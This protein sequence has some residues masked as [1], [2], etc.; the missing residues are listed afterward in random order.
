MSDHRPKTDDERPDP[1]DEP[2][3]LYSAHDAVLRR[4]DGSEIDLNALVDPFTGHQPA[5]AGPLR[6]RTHDDDDAE[7]AA[8]EQIGRRLRVM[9]Q[10]AGLSQKEVAERLAVPASKISDVENGGIVAGL[11]LVS[12]MVVAVGARLSDLVSPGGPDR[13]NPELTKLAVAA[14]VPPDLLKRID[15]EVEPDEYPDALARGFAWDRDELMTGEPHTPMLAFDPVYKTVGEPPAP[16]SPILALAWTLSSVA[17]SSY[18]MTFSG[19]PADPRELRREILAKHRSVALESVLTWSWD[20]GVV[21]LPL[22]AKGDFVAAVWMVEQ[23]PTIVL[24]E[25]RSIAAYWLFDLA[26]ELGHVALGHAHKG[27]VEVDNP[28]KPDPTDAQE[29]AANQYALNLLLPDPERLLA[30]VRKRT[31]GDAPRKFKFAVRDVAREA[32][33]SAGVLGLI[34]ANDMSDV[35]A[36]KDRWGSASNLAKAEG[37]TDGTASVRQAFRA[38]IAMDAISDLDAAILRAASLKG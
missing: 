38:R 12:A 23:T 33:V 9:R 15:A 29:Q 10:N 16:D 26:H 37:L 20:A 28:E 21:V 34:A 22:R 24:N 25:S 6:L 4:Q 5:A 13:S 8:R 14:G 31:A 18:P 17:A 32:G 36:D 19:V 3:V 2:L 27:I 11:S 1:F 7:R 35:P 30:D